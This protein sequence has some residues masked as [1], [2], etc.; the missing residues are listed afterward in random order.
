MDNQ[1]RR[2]LG[3]IGVA[4]SFGCGSATSPTT[5]AGTSVTAPTPTPTPASS[6]AGLP[7]M[8]GQFYGTQASLEGSFVVLRAT[9]VPDHNSPYFGPGKTGYEAPQAGMQVNPNLIVAQ[10][11][12][13][14]VPVSPASTT[15]SDTPLGVMGVA[16]NGVALFNQYAAMRAPLTS[17]ILSFDRYN[18]HPQQNGMYHYHIEPLYLTAQGS[19]R[20]VGVLLDGFPV[21]GT[22]D[23]GGATPSGLDSCNGH[24]GVTAEFPTGI[25]HYHIV[26]SPPYIAGCF[27]GQPGTAS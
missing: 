4:L 8:Y 17:E 14:R 9:S 21:Y 12:V 16:V 19:S 5:T 23:P 25:Y 7:A 20:L 11:M 24:V 18:G 15:A 1:L 13:L 6:A 3:P 10:N 26:A 27:R 22:R 2:I